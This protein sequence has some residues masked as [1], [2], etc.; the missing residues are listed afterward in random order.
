MA[1]KF[2]TNLNL[3]Q[4]Q[5]INGK[6]E[7]LASDPST[8]NFEGRLIYNSTEKTI[9]VYTGSAWRKMLHGITSTGDQSEA[10]TISEAN[11]A[12]TIQPNL[13]TSSF[14]G[15]MSAADKTKLDAATA[16]ETANTL[17]LRD[18]NGRFKA[19]TPTADLDVANKGYVDAART[20]L[21]VKASVKVATT[22]PITIATG[23]EAGD[24]IDG[25]TL[26]AGDR[27]LVKNQSTASENG[28][29]IASVSGAPSRATDA[30]N[31]AEVTPGMF[32]FVENGTLNADSGWVLITDGDIT[33]GTTGLAFSLFSV[34][35]NI[36]AGD[37]LS[38]TG[39]VLNVNTGVGIEIHSDALRIKSDAAGNG[40]GYDA[41]VLSVTI[42]GSTGLA[43]TSDA[44][45]IKLDSGI[46]GLAT[47]SDGL[48]IKSDIAG[49]GLTYTAGVLSRNV[50]DLGQ[51]SDDTT[52]T[53]PVDQG[54]TGATTESGA[55][56]NL[57]VGGDTGTRTS[58]TPTLAR[59][60]SQVIGDASA[61]SFAI[62]HNFNTRL[63]QTEVFD[64]ATF[65]TVIADVVR[66]N[67]NTVTVSFSVAPDAGAYTVVITG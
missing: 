59:K 30:D 20:G 2:V 40:L 60:T 66:T 63:V 64:S 47:T 46:A 10:I 62:V 57:A 15:V 38:K 18:G 6:F 28:I 23:L 14:D 26:V 56:D 45:G 11:G 42:G 4:N 41:G 34:A 43:I 31:N 12:V 7:V 3:N 39:D 19:A 65:D 51:G 32:T 33:V 44:V 8:D 61:T 24:V 21:D 9:K 17:V 52:G 25:Y 49:D 67:V 50:I 1:Q 48:K 5:L 54:G 29:Y 55:R 13:A 58:T 16:T 22:A 53:L 35:G 36:L 27:V 37:G